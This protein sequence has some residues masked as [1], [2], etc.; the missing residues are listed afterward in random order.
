MSPDLIVFGINALIRLGQQGNKAIIEYAAN[1]AAPFP[2]LTILNVDEQT[3][4]E[5]IFLRPEFSEPVQDGGRFADLWNSTNGTFTHWDD[6]IKVEILNTAMDLARSNPEIFSATFGYLY[7][8]VEGHELNTDTST[9]AI[10]FAMEQAIGA[11]LVNQWRPDAAPVSPVGRMAFAVAQV[12]LDYVA[13]DPSIVGV[14]G[15]R[16]KIVRSLAIALSQPLQEQLDSERMG[17][18]LQ[19]GEQLFFAFAEAGFKALREHSADLISD[20]HIALLINTA[21]EPVIEEMIAQESDIDAGSKLVFRLRLQRLMATFVGPAASAAIQV[22]ADNPAAYLGNNFDQAKLAGAMTSA[23]LRDVVRTASNTGSI[24]EVLTPEGALSLLRA[25]LTLAAERPALFLGDLGDDEI[26][27]MAVDLFSTYAGKLAGSINSLE[28]IR[29]IDAGQIVAVVA[30]ESLL[31]VGRNIRGIIDPQDDQWKAVAADLAKTVLDDLAIALSAPDGR[32]T[33]LMRAF[34]STKLT[35]LAKIVIRHI[36]AHPEMLGVDDADAGAIISV[37]AEAI[38]KNPGFLNSADDWLNLLQAAAGEL[39]RRPAFVAGAD[40]RLQL[41]VKALSRGVSEDA[42][43][44]FNPDEWVEYARLIAH[45]MATNPT[46]FASDNSELQNVIA[47]VTAAMAADRNLLLSGG[48]WLKILE[49]ALAQAAKNPARL[50]ELDPTD[51]GQMLAAEILGIVLG[52]IPEL[53]PGEFDVGA[54]VLDSDLVS[55]AT[56]AILRQASESSELANT[57]APM[58]TG[59]VTEV[60]DFVSENRGEFGGRHWLELVEALTARIF[61]GTYEADGGVPT[62]ITDV[63]EARILLS[64]G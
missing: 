18:A 43:K 46:V 33:V 52:A 59:A 4:A 36:A 19:V 35:E 7:I 3:K 29:D 30:S 41:V 42:S 10:E 58:I 50:F 38:A 26:S 63:A 47:A 17:T 57:Y 60:T 16:Q 5:E 15:T 37:T 64:Q 27:E 51:D 9:P 21:I 28:A 1:K 24:A 20:E 49:I 34:S 32:G 61:A 25:S 44:L 2:Q 56:T 31:A 55:D 13:I 45:A 54:F 48:D 12:A 14:D 6:H 23:L 53:T 11:H 40:Q 39:A 8:D 22:V 62:F